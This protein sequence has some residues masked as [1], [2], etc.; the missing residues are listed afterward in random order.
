MDVGTVQRV[1][2]EDKMRSAYLDYAMSVITSRALP[3]VRDG[4]KPV[5]RRILYA[6][7]DMGIRH[8]G[9]TR[10]S[11]RIVGEVLGKY[12]PHGDAAVYE[13][14]VRMAQGFSM[15]YPLVD[16]QGNFGS[17][18]GDGAAAMRYTEARLSAIGEE[19]LRDLDKDT[20]DFV[21][22]FDGSLQ[23]PTVLPGKLPNLVINGVGGIA[24][25]MA[26]NI[27]PHNLGEIVDAIVYLIEHYDQTDEV[28][29]DDLM[30]F[31][32]GPDFPTGGIILGDE[33]I[34]QAYATGKGKILVR[35]Q[36]HVED[37]AGG[38]CSIIVT[39]LPYQVNKANLVE[40]IAD[41]T[42]DERVQGIADL[43]DESD[44]TG[45]RVV[46][47][48]KRGQEAGPVLSDL[49][50]RTQL[51][52]TFGAN[53]LAL[54]DREP[55]LLSLKRILLY[56]V[57]HRHEVIVRRSQYE[58]ERALAR[59]H[60]LEGLL[61][62]LDHLDE[63]IATIRRSRTAESARS[64]L[65]KRFKLSEL[66]AQAILDMQ[67]RRLAAMER[68]KIEDELR[69][70]R[71]T[72]DSLR[73]L[74]ASKRKVLD[75]IKADLLELKSAYG[76]ARRTHIGSSVESTEYHTGDL[77][78]DQDLYIVLTQAGGVRQLPV[79]LASGRA[80]VPGMSSRETDPPQ[81]VLKANAQDTILFFSDAGRAF[82]LR[83][84][85][86]PDA[87][88]QERGL[89]LKSLVRVGDGEHIVAA[90]SLGALSENEYLSMA[91]RQGR[92]KRVQLGEMSAIGREPAQVI[93]LA[94]DDA[95]GWVVRT[96]GSGD[97]LMV[98]REGR[99]IRI[100]EDT[101]RPQGLAATGMRGM[102]LQEGDLIAGMDL[103]RDGAALAI[104]TEAGF[105]KRTEVDA[106]SVQGRGGQGTL[107]LDQGK[108]ALSGAVA[109]ALVVFPED[110]LVFG[111]TGGH[112]T[113]VSA[114]E[115][116]LLGRAT[117][118]RVV[119]RTRRSATVRVGDE[120]LL[121]AVRLPSSSDDGPSTTGGDDAPAEPPRRGK[122]GS[123]RRSS[124]GR[125]TRRRATSAKGAAAPPTEASSQPT[126]ES[127]ASGQEAVAEDVT[128]TPSR[129][130]APRR[131]PRTRVTRSRKKPSSEETTQALPA[132]DADAD[133]QVKPDS[134]AEA[135]PPTRTRRTRRGTVTRAPRRTR[136]SK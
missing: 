22:N 63:V 47:E 85:Q 127:A 92:V 133:T 84:Y 83:A 98:T 64:N 44:R 112:M 1:D 52:T 18:D 91:T 126:H 61:L 57:D 95:L 31:V 73:E 35:A 54:V 33:G 30:R 93:G 66:Q 135:K 48:L 43:R 94:D 3:D 55:R 132:T 129:S 128:P 38:R 79:S 65:I 58:L 71:D 27:P 136:T 103:V 23:E 9:P 75:L 106:Y 78:P 115:I 113:K 10:K 11:A 134:E 121:T 124:T 56:H 96:P 120:R 97:L 24:V 125:K 34:R 39:E 68:R 100:G 53:A 37:L 109:V 67:L 40:R 82:G 15:R 4:L 88:Q 76:D 50:K 2:I 36:A 13:A 45:M 122:G 5:Q 131:T 107:T 72:I 28:T 105:A 81:A 20:V 62:A 7:H 89:L 19:L 110:E 60:I 111:T 41:L 51:Q 119:T 46:I 25:G 77:V 90:L 26:T 80:N 16:G 99:A 12:H 114:H 49:L 86:L 59:A 21:E 69:Q 29:V 42:R 117:W 17:V 104:A 87:T 102:S 14:M 8:S 101:V 6:M 32:K 74:L 116:P 123:T 118:G 70:V 108:R 130:K